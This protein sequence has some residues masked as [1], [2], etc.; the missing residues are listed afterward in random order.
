MQ[1]RVPTR[2]Y[3]VVNMSTVKK[4]NAQKIKRIKPNRQSVPMV[5]LSISG[6]SLSVF[7]SGDHF[8]FVVEIICKIVTGEEQSI[9]ETRFIYRIHYVMLFFIKKKIR[10]K[11]SCKIYL[12]MIRPLLCFGF[13]RRFLQTRRSIVE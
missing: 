6:S 3:L 2:V 12:S 1:S 9:K 8:D 10:K 11:I 13:V 7:F 4:I 5:N